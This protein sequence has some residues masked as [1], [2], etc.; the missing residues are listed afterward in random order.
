METIELRIRHIPADVARKAK[1]EA[2]LLGLTL[3]DWIIA[4]MKAAIERKA[5]K[6]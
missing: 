5:G 4:A 6:R 3:N 1:S 2:A